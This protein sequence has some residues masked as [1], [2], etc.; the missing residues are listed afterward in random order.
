MKKDEVLGKSK[1]ELRKLAIEK[2]PMLKHIDFEVIELKEGSF[3]IRV[4]HTKE[5]ER[6][7][8]IVFGGVT[9]MIFDFVL[10]FTVMSVNDKNNQATIALQ[11]TY[12]RPARDEHYYFEGRLLKKGKNIVFVEGEM[13]NSKGK[14]L[15]KALGEWFIFD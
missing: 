9:A 3:K 10:G 15:A 1:E 8:G 7:G 6:Y 13:L 11:I 12:I 5:I 2:L 4:R 14:L